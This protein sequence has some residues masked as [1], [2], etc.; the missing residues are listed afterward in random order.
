MSF[1]LIL[2]P[3]IKAVHVMA[4]ISWMAGLFYLPRLFVYH[5]EQAKDKPERAE[6]FQIME[7]KLFRGIM[8]PAM[9]V[10]WICGL[11][12]V[13]IG[14]SA[15][16]GTGWFGVKFL[17]VLLMSWFHNWCGRERKSLALGQFN[18]DGKYYRLM[19]EIPT[20]LMV[21]IVI[22]VIVKPF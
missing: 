12:M 20:I 13:L 7:R 17:C 2:Y 11:A 4:V 16:Y 1:W 18:H 6:M 8:N 3:W 10:T 5:V 21:V 19:N 15:I 9:N 14:G 22:M